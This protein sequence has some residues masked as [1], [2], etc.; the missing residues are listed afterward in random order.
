MPVCLSVRFESE[1]NQLSQGE[2]I[3]FAIRPQFPG[4]LKHGSLK[5]QSC[6][7]T[8]PGQTILFDEKRGQGRMFCECSLPYLLL[9]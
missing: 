3:A 7:K 1:S 6:V 4:S 9:P 8:H 5:S 2:N